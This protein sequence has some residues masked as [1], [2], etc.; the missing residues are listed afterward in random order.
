MKIIVA[1]V[2]AA[3]LATSASHAFA[4]STPDADPSVSISYADLDLSTASGRAALQA[5]INVAVDQVCPRSDIRKLEMRQY[6]Q[7]CRSKALAG[8]EQQLAGVYAHGQM[9]Q[10]SIHV[11]SRR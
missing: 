2:A 9:A 8:A 6:E 1:T 4:Q 7:A 5:R 11:S 10:A 3:L